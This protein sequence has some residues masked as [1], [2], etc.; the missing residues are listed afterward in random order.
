MMNNINYF[1]YYG[2]II[3]IRACHNNPVVAANNNAIKPNKI[4]GK[5][6]PA[7][8]KKDIILSI[9]LFCLIAHIKP[10]GIAIN[11]IIISAVKD[12]RIVF[13]KHGNI[14]VDTF[15]LYEKE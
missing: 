15:I 1:S 4:S 5:E 6:S 7:K 13:K 8:A 12:N 2:K 11:H 9:N 3:K 10:N 14:N